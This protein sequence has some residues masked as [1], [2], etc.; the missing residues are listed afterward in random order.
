MGPMA[1][2]C[3]YLVYFFH[4]F[5]RRPRT[6]TVHVRLGHCEGFG[7]LLLDVDHL[8]S[9]LEELGISF[10]PHWLLTSGSGGKR[11]ASWGT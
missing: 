6:D 5:G 2:D 7:E 10:V 8:S 11:M 9:L 4:R 3:E 1:C